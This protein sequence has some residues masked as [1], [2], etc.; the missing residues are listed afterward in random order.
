MSKLPHLLRSLPRNPHRRS[1]WSSTEFSSWQRRRRRC[2]RAGEACWHGLPH[3]R[4]DLRGSRRFLLRDLRNRSESTGLPVRCSILVFV[5]PNLNLEHGWNVEHRP[6]K[7][8]NWSE[9][10]GGLLPRLRGR[11]MRAPGQV[12]H[13]HGPGGDRGV[14]LLHEGLELERVVERA[15][16][17]PHKAFVLLHLTVLKRRRRRRKGGRT[18]RGRDGGRCFTTGGWTQPQ[19]VCDTK[20][21]SHPVDRHSAT[22]STGWSLMRWHI[23]TTSMEERCRMKAAF[24]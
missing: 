1:W 15:A 23:L 4:A 6:E 19:R 9:E 2:G 24:F 8:A 18:Y 11:R 7:P 21:V 13:R 17:V 3:R 10:L 22:I 12:R 20:E 5:R 14:Q 16:T